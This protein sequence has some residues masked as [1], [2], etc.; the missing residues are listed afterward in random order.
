[1][2][3]ITMCSTR[4]CPLATK[5]Y[6]KTATPSEHWQSYALF[7]AAISAYNKTTCEHY[8]KTRMEK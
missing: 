8:I 4:I 7:E 6:R 3:D 2:P 5:C 1:M